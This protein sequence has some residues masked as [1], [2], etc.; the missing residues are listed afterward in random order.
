MRWP[1][2]Q[3][4]SAHSRQRGVTQST[5]DA[6]FTKWFVGNIDLFAAL[7]VVTGEVLHQIRKPHAGVDV[8]AFV[9]WIDRHTPTL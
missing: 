1:Q 7:Y 6:T 2:P 9:K 5:L 8:L 3:P 4:T